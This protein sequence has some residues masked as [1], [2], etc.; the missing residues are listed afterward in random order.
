MDMDDFS[1]LGIRDDLAGALA[2]FGFDGPTEI[3]SLAVPSLLERRDA[4]I[5]A[6]TGTGKTFAY[7]A[8]LLQLMPAACPFIHGLI[9][10]PTH[11]LA[12]Q[13]EKELEK[14]AK[15]AGI[16]TR[17]ALL[18]GSVQARRQA[19]Q[20][21]KGCEVAIGT[22]G[23]VRDLMAAGELDISNLSFIVLDEA[24]RLFEKETLPET[25]E[26]LE[27]V[28]ASCARVLVSA[29]LPDRVRDKATPWFRD[30]AVLVLDNAQALREC[31][32]HWVF[33]AS[34]RKKIDFLRRFEA[35][36]KPSKCLVFT[37]SNAQV[38]N[39]IR[40]L[41]HLGFPA[42]DLRSQ[43]DK[44]RR[45]HALEAFKAG[46]IRYL[47]TSDLGAR[48]MDVKG[49]DYVLCMDLP[50][51]PTVY[52]H[53]AGRT[54]RAGERGT[55]VLVA[56]LFELKRA[57][58][59]AVRYGFVFQCKI[60][61]GGEVRDIDPENFFALA[62]EEESE[63]AVKP[64]LEARRFSDMEGRGDRKR[65]GAASGARRS[66]E[67]RPRDASRPRPG[68]D[69]P[70]RPPAVKSPSKG[71]SGRGRRQGRGKRASGGSGA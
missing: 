53:R 8:P 29:T 33:H 2:S 52:V 64:P 13:V 31:M 71:G 37:S 6:A 11:E 27:R 16:K 67:R 20:L 22:P 32:D 55:S 9:V 1:R 65:K 41:E 19:E 34:S 12:V 17:V 38:F 39:I 58:K 68:V 57:S 14:L 23:R 46:E 63:R 10:T 35:A 25:A 44:E 42:A 5:S 70:K 59:V 24:D 26:I 49:I 43:G 21:R 36:V 30:P 7:L 3:Q 4:Y 60:L 48:G 62:E 18:I 50:E 45:K 66:A 56:D 28:P 47:V 54:G 61:E 15:A 40:K 69:E 51:E